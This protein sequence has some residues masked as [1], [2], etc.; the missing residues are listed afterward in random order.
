[1]FASQDWTSRCKRLGLPAILALSVVAFSLSAGH[2][3]DTRIVTTGSQFT[4]ALPENRST[5]Y[6]WQPI[7]SKGLLKLKRRTYTRNTTR[8]GAGGT[9]RFVFVALRPGRTEIEFRYQRPW[10]KLPA[11]V[12]RVGIRIEH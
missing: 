8:L 1:M 6:S 7:Y 2:A 12:R 9:A 10:E 3:G 5:G 11:D 4:V